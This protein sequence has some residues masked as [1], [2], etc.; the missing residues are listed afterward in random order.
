MAKDLRGFIAA[1]E[2]QSPEDIVRI[3]KPISPRY[4]MSA[5]LTHLE[6]RK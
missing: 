2:T 6:K 3:K 4:E 1:L 5:I